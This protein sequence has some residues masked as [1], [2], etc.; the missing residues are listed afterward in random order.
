MCTRNRLNKLKTAV[1]AALAMGSEYDW[2]LV[3][4]D[5]GSTDGTGKYLA[6]TQGA[7]S[8]R[9]VVVEERR[10]GTG[11]AR[12]SGWLVASADV[13]AFTDDDCYVGENYVA[14]MMAALDEDSSV[15]V[16]AGRV[17]RADPALLKT[18]VI[19][20]DQRRRWPPRSFVAAGDALTANM[21]F[22]REALESTGGFD[23]ILGSGTPFP[24]EDIDAFAAVLWK[25]FAGAYDPRP[26]VYHDHGRRT[27][28]DVR[29][30]HRAYDAGRGAYYAKYLRRADSRRVYAKEWLK[31][32]R[33]EVKY[34][35]SFAYSSREIAAAAKHRL[36]VRRNIDAVAN[37][38][39]PRSHRG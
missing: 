8:N 30:I 39:C 6:E 35:H 21:A 11:Y 22:R 31:T 24:S 13:I 38:D 26:I 17:Q 12:N 3:V 29:P 2:E 18:A 33:D 14:C 32:M 36:S 9:M 19:E 15:G 16:V 10:R 37:R 34:N 28:E 27:E 4:V 23:P 20:R 25:G 7:T 1:D 5:N